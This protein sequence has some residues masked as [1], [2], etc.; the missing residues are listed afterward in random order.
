MEAITPILEP[1]T[2]AGRIS[3]HEVIADLLD[4]V[5]EKL[6]ASCDLRPSD[7]YSGYSAKVSIEL[8]L[9]D[10]DQTE[11][12]TEVGVGAMNPQLESQHITLS[13]PSVAAVAD[14]SA[15]L[16]RPIDPSG[17]AG[18]SV[19]QRRYYTPRGSR[20]LI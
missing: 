17:V 7:S 20:P 14:D 4:R 15:L 1:V 5:A 16:E 12:V 10:V 2:V 19:K 3:G 13:A 18:A 8:Q 9:V 6:P 11:V